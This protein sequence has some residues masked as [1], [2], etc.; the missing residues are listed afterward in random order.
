MPLQALYGS[1]HISGVIGFMPS[2]LK[3]PS[4]ASQNLPQDVM[5]VMSPLARIC[6][7]G[8]L[9]CGEMQLQAACM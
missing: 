1:S 7:H 3:Q 6:M 5:Y 4:T 2:Q 8:G 9:R